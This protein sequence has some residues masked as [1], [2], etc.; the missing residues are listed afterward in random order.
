MSKRWIVQATS[1]NAGSLNAT[2]TS[3]PLPRAAAE[4]LALDWRH[5]KGISWST[6]IMP[7]DEEPEPEQ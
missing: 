7:A 2:R 4:Q 6:R 3:L 5:S 1:I